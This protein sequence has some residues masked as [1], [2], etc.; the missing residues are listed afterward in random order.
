MRMS[1]GVKLPALAGN[2]QVFVHG[3]MVTLA[4]RNPHDAEVARRVRATK[5]DAGLPS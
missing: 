5:E 2:E 1:A 4:T 3:L